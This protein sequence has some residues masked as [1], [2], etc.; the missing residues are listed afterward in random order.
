MVGEE[1]NIVVN[2]VCQRK[3]VQCFH[4]GIN[5]VI[6]VHFDQD[7]GSAVLKILKLMSALPIGIPM[8]KAMK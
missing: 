1:G 2:P 5:M 3:P 8:R 6:F 4:D 7:P